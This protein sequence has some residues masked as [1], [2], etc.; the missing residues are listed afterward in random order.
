[1]IVYK[2]IWS[3]F[4]ENQLDDIFYYYSLKASKSIAKR[5]IN[6]ILTEVRVLKN[7]PNIGQ[8]ELLLSSLQEY[9]YIVSG[10]YKVIYRMDS[11]NMIVKITD[12]FDTRQNPVKISRNK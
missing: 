12:V 2:I 11:K 4:A 9:R 3:T 8:S 5:I 10:N 1:M 6:K 7:H